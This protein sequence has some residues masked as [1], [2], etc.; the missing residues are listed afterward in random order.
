MR[1]SLRNAGF[2]GIFAALIVLTQTGC[3]SGTNVAGLPAMTQTESQS[4]RTPSSISAFPISI[5]AFPVSI[6][7]FPILSSSPI[8][9]MAFPI[10]KLSTSLAA[11]QCHGQYRSDILSILN[12]LLPALLAPGHHPADLQAAYGLASASASA[13]R[14][15]TVAVVV[16]YDAPALES[17][18]NI[19]RSAFGLGSCKTSN[20]C[21]SIIPGNGVKPVADA[22]WAQEATLD[23]EMVS[24]VCPLCH[25]MVVE[26]QDADIVHLAAA[27]NTAAANHATVISNSYSAPESAEVMQYASSYVHKGIPVT[28]GA[29]DRGYGV[30][31][32]ADVPQVTSVGGTSLIHYLGGWAQA[33]WPATGSGCSA[34]AAKPSWQ[35]DT[36]CG[37]RTMNDLAVVADPATG[38]S[39]YVSGVGG[40]NEFGGTSVGA[41]LVAGMYAL[42]GNGTQL[43][44][45]S[46]L[47]AHASA[48]TPVVPRSNGQCS[49]AYLCNGGP[50][51]S[52]PAGLGGPSGLGAF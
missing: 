29:G 13:G 21:L 2:A 7:A 28:A 43:G 44:D 26:A 42:A 17:D 15:Q 46:S 10:C 14:N 33:V 36:G 6:S 4:A 24:A 19:Y 52:G 27:V 41:P 30:G 25:I 8:S 47:Y 49:P 16:A 12:P 38:V 23:V 18:L 31:F 20:G 5:S 9:I 3:S 37:K 45:T 22:G 40:W 50:G 39:A 35:R 32:P 1:P 51:Y 34:F 48:F 11:A